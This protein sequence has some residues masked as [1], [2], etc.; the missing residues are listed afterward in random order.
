LLWQCEP[1]NENGWSLTHR[2]EAE[3]DKFH[4]YQPALPGK[5][6]DPYRS[7]R[8]PAGYC[9]G[10]LRGNTHQESQFLMALP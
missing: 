10:S 3:S 2:I 1:A 5:L 6:F 8:Y 7:K 9:P 4:S